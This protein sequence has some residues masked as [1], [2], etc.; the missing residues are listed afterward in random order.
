MGFS[1]SKSLPLCHSLGFRSP[2]IR[3]FWAVEHYV[4]DPDMNGRLRSLVPVT[5]LLAI[6]Y[7]FVGCAANADGD[8]DEQVE[9][10]TVERGPL[11]VSITAVGS[12]SPRAEA[13]LSFGTGGEV[14][15][16]LV[17]AGARVRKGQELARLETSDLE[18]QV[19]S[20]E[21]ALAAAQAQLDQLQ[22]GT[23]AEDIAS[24]RA[25]LDAA[26]ARLEGAKADLRAL[27]KG[28]DENQIET[29]EAD[30]R[31]AQASLE[32]AQVQRDRLNEGPSAAVVADAQ[33]RLVSAQSQQ[34]VA[35]DRHDE[36]LKCYEGVC[37]MLGTL[38]EQA[39]FD[40]QAAD[41]AVAAAQSQLNQLYAGP[42]PG[43]IDEAEARLAAAQAQVDAV[44][45]QLDLLRSGASLETLQAAQSNVDA[46]Q[47]QAEATQAQL[48]KLLTGV[49]P[50][51]IATAKANLAQARVALDLAELALQ[52]AVL[53][54]P[55][56]GVVSKLDI[57]PGE[58]VAPQLPIITL[59]DDSTFRIEVDVDEAD[60]GWVQPGQEVGLNLDSFP[61]KTLIG[62][63]VGIDT[64]ATFEG[65]VVSYGVTIETDPMDL[66]LRGGMT[67]NAEI[68]TDQRE[69]VLLVPNRAIWIDAES[70][71]P[72][73]ERRLAE[74]IVR[75]NIEQGL[76]ND[77]FSEVLSGLNQDDTLV[78]RSASVRERFREMMTSS[79]GG[80]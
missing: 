50:G 16:V 46:L 36:T 57:E 79:M 27:Q 49:T 18:L 72:F 2:R 6:L 12:V 7:V 19:Q 64:A 38:E 28:A 76:A 25:N 42:T 30:L 74:D 47:A 44:Q 51:E 40:L 37:P 60:I 1:G 41:A 61:G 43:Q 68:V 4:E 23:R 77:E 71:Q 48:D 65:G 13:R 78:V 29:A 15:D 62:R 20:A 14:S 80:Q 21:A 5:A 33:A 39:R 75:V 54:A 10:V 11:T 31:A 52:K 53:K 26:E 22:A 73:V 56:D 45:A 55:F 69:D 59:L 58:Y 63:V 24:A 17:Q 9:I 3:E 67:V 34:K 70:G 35:R 32:L 8:A 66:P